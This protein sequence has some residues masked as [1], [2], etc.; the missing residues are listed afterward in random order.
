MQTFAIAPAGA[1]PLWLLLPVVVVLLGVAFLLAR[2]LL[3]SQGARFELS[4][5]GLRLVGDVYGR[6]IPAAQLRAADAR[7]VDLEREPALAPRRRK[8]GTGLPGYQA[9]WFELENGEK[10]LLYLTDR[11]RAVYVPTSNGYGVL[12]SP[13]EPDAFLEALRGAVAA[14]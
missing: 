9:G 10:A 14:H 5:A 1:R 8:L 13:S 2:T 7:R 6:F 4:T 3:G 11:Q 12:L